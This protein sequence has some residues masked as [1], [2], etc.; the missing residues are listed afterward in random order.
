MSVQSMIGALRAF[1]L[2][3]ALVSLP[4][5]ASPALAAEIAGLWRT[6]HGPLSLVAGADGE[7][8]GTYKYKNLPANFYGSRLQ[9]T[10]LWD[11]VW[12]Q[13]TSE[14]TCAKTVRGSRYWGR[15]MFYIQ[16]DVMTGAWNYCGRRIV[17]RE[18]RLWRGLRVKAS[19]GEP[20]APFVAP[21][22]EGLDKA[23]Q[24]HLR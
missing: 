4:T 1:L 21:K 11:G 14:V 12:V 16:G 17:M 23:L 5:A 18:N 2:S 22:N 9:D 13:Q 15:V 10:D 7:V 20:S 24:R 8:T 3:L 6:N 19:T